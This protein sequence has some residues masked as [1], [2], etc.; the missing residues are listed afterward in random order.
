MRKMVPF[1]MVVPTLRRPA[2]SVPSFVGGE[3]LRRPHVDARC[4]R[5]ADKG[6]LAELVD[7]HDGPAAGVMAGNDASYLQS[8]V[9]P[10]GSASAAPSDGDV[11]PETPCPRLGARARAR[12]GILASTFASQEEAS[13]EPTVL[14]E[15]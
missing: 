14:V 4:A 9:W 11:V 10:P 8:H 13:M 6:V 12:N 2:S 7:V 3:A 5:A 1:G 15:K